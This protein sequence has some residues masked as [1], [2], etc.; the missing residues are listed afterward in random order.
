MRLFKGRLPSSH[1]PRII[2][3][4]LVCAVMACKAVAAPATDTSYRLQDNWQNHYIN[5]PSQ[6]EWLDIQGSPDIENWTSQQWVFEWVANDVYRIK[7]VWTSLYLV[8]ASQDEWDSIRT[9]ALREDWGSMQWRVTTIANE[10]IRLQNVWSG[11]YLSSSE[12]DWDT[13]RQAPLNDSWSS[14][15]FT[16]L[17]VNPSTGLYTLADIPIGVAVETY[18]R[19]GKTPEGDDLVRTQSSDGDKRRTIVKENFNQL[20]AQNAHKM[21]SLQRNY[22]EFYFGDCRA[23]YAESESSIDVGD[24]ACMMDFA[25]T[26]GMDV[27]FHTLLWYRQAPNW[28]RG[29]S[30]QNTLEQVD[31]NFDGSAGREDYLKEMYYHIDNVVCEYAND[32]RSI[33][34]VNEAFSDFSANAYRVMDDPAKQMDWAAAVGDDYMELAFRR[35]EQKLDECR[36]NG[37]PNNASN[38][39]DLYY[40]D[41]QLIVN[42]AKLQSV[43]TM[44]NSFKNASPAVPIDGIGI[45]MHYNPDF[46]AAFTPD[47]VRTGLRE[48]AST[49]LKIKIT[50]MDVRGDLNND[51]TLSAQEQDTQKAL[52]E[53][54]INIYFQEVPA[55]QRGGISF[56]GVSDKYSW[57]EHTKPLLFDDN[58]NAK[59]ALDGVRRALSSN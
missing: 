5:T 35:T 40:N 44:V 53:E 31:P 17:P 39:V 29:G 28:L 23:S 38:R 11:L 55:A 26:N 9:A 51:Q 27:H 22:H 52:Y 30:L 25:K 36:T 49:G 14:Q 33:D 16:L 57:L 24:S 12:A 20:S 7:N 59:P 37:N 50:E 45:Q 34:V 58:L 2:F 19:G 56:W 47:N 13:L 46:N 8:A 4:I 21:K 48:L 43:M 32:I 54:L 10:R 42:D 18:S 15:Q 41:Y 6:D 3:V 1:Y